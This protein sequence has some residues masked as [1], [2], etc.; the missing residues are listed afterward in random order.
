MAA[1]NG[2]GPAMQ[3]LPFRPSSLLD[4]IAKFGGAAA[5]VA[6]VVSLTLFFSGMKSDISK[7]KDESDPRN[8][9]SIPSAM[10]NNTLE[11]RRLAKALF[12]VA[13]RLAKNNKE[14]LAAISALQTEYYIAPGPGT[15]L[16]RSPLRPALNPQLLYARPSRIV[17]GMLAITLPP[18][19]LDKRVPVLA[20]R[21]GTVLETGVDKD[22]IGADKGKRQFLDIA[23]E[24]GYRHR[25]SNLSEVRVTQGASVAQGQVIADVIPTPEACLRVGILDPHGRFIDPR[26]FLLPMREP[27]NEK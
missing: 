3:P 26:R 2:G 6:V 27:P 21:A 23:L 9:Y 8:P 15:R 19:H 24:F 18:E 22:A 20:M 25:Y 16:D 5:G 17:P 10:D 12:S 7:L 11:L 1:N 4:K 14:D 13:G